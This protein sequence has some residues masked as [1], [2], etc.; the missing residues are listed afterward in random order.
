M[1]FSHLQYIYTGR[2]VRTTLSMALNALLTSSARSP[3]DG[4]A[5]DDIDPGQFKDYY[6]PASPISKTLLYHVRN[7][8]AAIDVVQH[9]S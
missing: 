9:S 7:R 6:Y 2:R 1:E 5:S 4:W 8:Q 3:W